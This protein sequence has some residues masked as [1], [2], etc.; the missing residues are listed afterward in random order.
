VDGNKRVALATSLVFLSENG[1]LANEELDP[2]AW[3]TLTLA[4]AAGAL[5]REAVTEKLRALVS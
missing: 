3:E 1:L 5:A 2:D 4:V